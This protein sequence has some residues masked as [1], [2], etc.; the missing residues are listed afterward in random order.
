VTRITVIND[1]PEFLE[2]M[3]DIL[4]GAGGHAGAGFDGEQTTIEQIVDSRPELLIVDLRLAGD[5]MRGWD[6]L[7]L[8][9]SEESLRD[10]PLVV[11][12]ADV[13]TLRARAEE[14]K[15]IGNIYALEKPFSVEDVTSLVDRAIAEQTD[16][17]QSEDRSA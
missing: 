6:M 14:F 16:L 3:Y 10:V 11:C 5:D 1:Y 13:E 9:R 2:T 12:S 17:G 8:A 4:D 15:R 7:L